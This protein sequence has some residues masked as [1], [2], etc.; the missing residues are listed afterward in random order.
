MTGAQSLPL[1]GSV[2]GL[3]CGAAAA[4]VLQLAVG[5]APLLV[6]ALVVAS[7]LGAL[8]GA[9]QLPPR[10]LA[11]GLTLGVCSIACLCMGRV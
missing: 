7:L 9:K 6:L 8:L 1:I 11:L 4:G 5:S 2:E 3:V 10:A